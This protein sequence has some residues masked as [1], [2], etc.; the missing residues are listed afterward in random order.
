[1]T[2]LRR[3][4]QHGRGGRP[5][6][7]AGFS[8]IELMVACVVALIVVF[9]ISSLPGSVLRYFGEGAE[10]LRLQQDVHRVAQQI[11]LEVRKAHAFWI[12]DPANPATKLAA[13]P[14]VRLLDG[15]APPNTLAGFRASSDGK[16]VV[17]MA[18]EKLSDLTLADLWFQAGAD[19][20]LV[21]SLALRDRRGNETPLETR[22]T[23]RN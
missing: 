22:I 4:A 18:G 2:P 21:L 17:N 12:Y 10:R 20:E 8:T 6:G 16:S 19:S 3:M 11:G 15:N 14:A 13:G 1:M 7:P 9:G 23:P 5:A